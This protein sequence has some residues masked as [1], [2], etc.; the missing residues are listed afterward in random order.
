MV[1]SA[2]G[3]GKTFVIS[4]L[5]FYFLVCYNDVNIR[6]LSPSEQ[7]LRTVFM[8]EINKHHSN[9]HPTFQDFYDVKS[10][11][12][13]H[14][15]KTNNIAVCVTANPERSENVSGVHAET[16]I[17][18][19]DEASGIADEIY[20][21]TLGSL[22]TAQNGGYFIG[23]SNPNRGTGGNFY[24]D[25]FAKMVSGWELLTFTAEKCKMISKEWIEEMKTIYGEDGDEYRVSVL[26]EFP[27]ADG[28]SF[29]PESIIE[30]AI[31][32]I[33]PY[34]NYNTYPII[35]GVDIA[36]SL[37]GD[38]T[39]FA[40]RQGPKLLD[41]IALQTINTMEIVAKLKDTFK[42]YPIVAAYGDSTGVGG[43]VLDRAREL[44]INITDVIA[45]GTS[46]DPLQYA[47]IRTELWG[48]MREWL[49]FANIPD[50]YDLKR[51]LSTMTWGYSGRMQMQLTSKKQLKSQKIPSPDHADALALTFFDN[52]QTIRRTNIKPRLI[53][54]AQVLWA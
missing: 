17:Y 16:Q 5:T 49:Q 11:S 25:L 15:T 43:P 2:R 38:K 19:L 6:I 37:S 22:G 45:A 4:G 12:I 3:T 44:G 13:S 41:L 53:Q 51:E 30:E 27:R 29:I 40:V 28:S 36:R 7:Q 32:R 10:M 31:T 24:S 26:G 23:V 39:V 21:T 9:M 54:P 42:A 47:N 46:R 50:H 14:K 34:Q 35:L 18:L 48:E 20:S 33:I 8:R 52:H 1:K